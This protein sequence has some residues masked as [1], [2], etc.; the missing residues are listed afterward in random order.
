MNIANRRNPSFRMSP[1][2][3]TDDSKTRNAAGNELN[4][5]TLMPNC[6]FSQTLH[7]VSLG[8]EDTIEILGWKYA[9]EL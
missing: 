5:Y 3:K 9:R 8:S 1:A 7:E 2:V 6:Y 4:E